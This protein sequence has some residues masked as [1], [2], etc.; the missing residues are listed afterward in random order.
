VLLTHHGRENS[1]PPRATFGRRLFAEFLGSGLLTTVVVGSGIMARTLSPSDVGLQLFENAAATAAG[2]FVLILALG[3]VSG[4]HVNPVISCVDAAFCRGRWRDA[5]SYIPC[6]VAGC[7]SGAML[8]NVMFALPVVSMSTHHRATGPHVVSEIVATAGLVI[9]VFAL[10]RT[11][12]QSRAPAAVGAYIGGAYFFTSSS[13]FANPAIAIGRMFSNSFAGIAPT[14]VPAFVLAEVGGGVIG[15]A[16]VHVLFARSKSEQAPSLE[17]GQSDVIVKSS[18]VPRDSA[19][20]NR[21]PAILFLCVHNAGRSQMAAAFARELGGGDVTVW[22]AGSTPADRVHPLVVTAMAERGI[23]VGAATPTGLNDEMG[24]VADVIVTMGCGD[25]CPVYPGAKYVD[26]DLPDPAGQPLE[27][28]RLIR[29]AIEL[30]VRS[31]ITVMLDRPIVEITME[32]NLDG[33]RVPI[34]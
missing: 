19:A 18:A 4:A 28:V 9:V 13:S 29:D 34:P 8:A 2:L 22:S 27:I 15:Y 26:W 3:D 33:G 12:R 17:I 23:D 32:S 24:R 5:F 7:V 21:P 31:L 14:S 30:R 6:Q 10:Q 1:K 20:E 25:Q 16:V 11:G